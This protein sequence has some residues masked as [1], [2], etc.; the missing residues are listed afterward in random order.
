MK[1]T[2]KIFLR[3]H[4]LLCLLPH[5][6]ISSTTNLLCLQKKSG[7]NSNP[8]SFVSISVEAMKRLQ[9]YKKNNL[10]YK[11]SK[12]IATDRLKEKIPLLQVDRMPF[13][14]VEYVIEF[15]TYTNTMYVLHLVNCLG[16]LNLK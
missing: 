8:E 10:V 5:L 4:S 12:T 9:D 15:H 14:L 6:K 13:G 3:V 2:C 11:F 1:S 7:I 16:F